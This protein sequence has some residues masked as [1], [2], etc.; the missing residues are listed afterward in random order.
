MFPNVLKYGV[1]QLCRFLTH[2]QLRPDRGRRNFELNAV[3]A[4]DSRALGFFPGMTRPRHHNKRNAV[5]YLTP[6][7]PRRNL[8]ERIAA[9]NKVKSI[10]RRQRR[11][12]LLNG[13]DGVALPGAR[14]EIRCFEA[15]FVRHRE[16]E[17]RE[18]VRVRRRQTILLVRRDSIR[19]EKDTLEREGVARRASNGEVRIMH[20]VERP[21]KYREFQRFTLA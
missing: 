15:R 9:N 18:A 11:F 7:M 10:F 13:Q 12:E 20:R 17:H 3:E 2:G 19:D 21:S 14:L 1:R 5:D 6:A 16:S 4:K 8:C